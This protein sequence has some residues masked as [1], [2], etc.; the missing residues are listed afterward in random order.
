MTMMIHSF[1]KCLPGAYCVM[2]STHK[3]E[4]KQI[5]SSHLRNLHS[6]VK[7]EAIQLFHRVPRMHLGG[8][9]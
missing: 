2:G 5:I 9:D 4:K 7:V 8:V 3:M 1:N 6:D